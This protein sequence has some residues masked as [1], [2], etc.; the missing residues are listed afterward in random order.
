MKAAVFP[1][2]V[3]FSDVEFTVETPETPVHVECDGRLI[4][5]ALSNLIKNAGES[6]GARIAEH[7]GGAPGQV[8]V[9]ISIEDDNARICVIDNGVGL[10]SAKRHRLA[11]PYMT[12]REK[13]TGLGLAIV[14]KV[15]EEHGG[16]LDFMD[17]TSLGETGAR[18]TLTLPIA[19]ADEAGVRP[20]AAAAE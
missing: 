15:A 3:T 12:T 18:I 16:A 2:K 20:Q 8:K 5:Q 7:E 17:D 9:V 6:I 19:K 4:V 14:K 10:P 1:Q 13:G 11:E